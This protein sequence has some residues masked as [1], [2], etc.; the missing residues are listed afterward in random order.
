MVIGY[1]M[2]L[3]RTMQ[4]LSLICCDKNYNYKMNVRKS[5]E[6]NVYKQFTKQFAF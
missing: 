1:T 5:D 2:R 3:I 4:D 6:A